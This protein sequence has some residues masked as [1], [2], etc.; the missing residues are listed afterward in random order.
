MPL[1]SSGSISFDD[2][3]LELGNEPGTQLDMS[4]SAV[5][6]S[7]TA[8]HGMDEFYGLS[9]I[10][11]ASSISVNPSSISKPNTAKI[12]NVISVAGKPLFKHGR[13]Y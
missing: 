13:F 7:L 4:S 12:R 10:E 1:P 9:L 8:P 3:N 11:S 5:L 6:F 2:L